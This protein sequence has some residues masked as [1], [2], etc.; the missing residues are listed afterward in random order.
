MT[1]GSWL[2]ASSNRSIFGFDSSAVGD[3]GRTTLQEVAAYLEENPSH[4]I[5]V[6][7]HCDW[8]GTS[9]YNLALGDRR[10][11]SVNDYLSTLGHR[12]AAR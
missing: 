10:A 7:G 12:P 2:K 6:E 8:Y 9:E 4:G 5:L 1:D 11:G 3:S